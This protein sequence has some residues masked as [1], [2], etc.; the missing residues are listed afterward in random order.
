MERKA[1]RMSSPEQ[2]LRFTHLELTNWMNFAKTDFGLQQRVFVVGPNAA[3]KS[4]LLDAIRFLADIVAVGGGFQEAVYRRGG[5]GSLRYLGAR[6]SS[7]ITIKATVGNDDDQRV[8]EYELTFGQDSEM[9]PIVRREAVS[10]SNDKKFVLRPNDQDKMNNRLLTQTHLEQVS[11]QQGFLGLVDFLTSLRYQHVVPEQIRQRS[12]S[13]ERSYPTYSPSF[14][15]EIAATA[16]DFRDSRLNDIAK[17]LNS[18][19][20]Q[21]T[22]LKVEPGRPNHLSARYNDWRVR[23]TWQREDKLSDGT[24]RLIGLLW[25]LQDGTG[26]LLIEE[27][28]LS[29]HYGVIQYVPQLLARVCS[30]TGRQVIVSTHSSELLQDEGISPEEVL[31]LIPE[32]DGTKV[33]TANSIEDIDA[34][35]RSGRT[36]SQVLMPLTATQNGDELALFEVNNNMASGKV[37]K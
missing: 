3:G 36:L 24:L 7:D 33:E 4:N 15:D 1:I 28:E 2:N 27:P 25:A 8:W 35:L 29:L 11:L 26:P 17:A 14:I 9:G 22:E 13:L 37:S 31:L 30:D 10:G 20:P 6:R 23:G 12:S 18:I 32:E 34:L 19:L 5:A 21:F 16:A